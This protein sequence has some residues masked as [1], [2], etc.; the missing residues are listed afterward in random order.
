MNN[1]L[2]IIVPREEQFG[3]YYRP[4]EHMENMEEDCRE[5]F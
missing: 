5:V 4:S 2:N 1:L 3:G